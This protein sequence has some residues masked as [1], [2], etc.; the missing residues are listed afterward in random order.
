MKNLQ[1]IGIILGL[2][3][4]LTVSTILLD[5]LLNYQ[6][7]CEYIAISLFWLASIVFVLFV[8]FFCG[9]FFGIIFGKFYVDLSKDKKEG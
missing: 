8:T 3:I 1:N 7:V 4:G 6:T 5:L 2:I 9:R